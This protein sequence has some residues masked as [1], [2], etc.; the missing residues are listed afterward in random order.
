MPSFQLEFYFVGC[1]FFTERLQF[2]ATFSGC[3]LWPHFFRLLFSH[4]FP[5]F[6]FS[7]TPL[8]VH[9]IRTQVHFGC[10]WNGE[11]IWVQVKCEFYNKYA[12]HCA[13][14]NEH[15]MLM[16]FGRRLL[17]N[18]QCSLRMRY[19]Y[20]GWNNHSLLKQIT[21]ILWVAI[22]LGAYALLEFQTKQFRI[23][24]EKNGRFSAHFRFPFE[25]PSRE[26]AK[27]SIT[28]ATRVATDWAE[29][30]L[31]SPLPKV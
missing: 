16:Y 22:L 5:E 12:M 28:F 29:N 6:L 14:K 11:F 15:L 3:T 1:T 10:N 31:C 2:H 9:F 23:R 25:L 19:F 8:F 13:E 24:N 7:F 30:I 20:F 26:K 18:L 21:I 27:N 17:C 4:T